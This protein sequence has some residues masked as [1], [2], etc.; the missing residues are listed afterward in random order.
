MSRGPGRARSCELC[1]NW[2]VLH[3]RRICSA[4]ERWKRDHPVRAVCP[5]CRHEDH[6]G[7]DG[8]CR[9]CLRAVRAE[10]DI[11][12]ALALP[13]ARPRDRQ[14]IIGTQRHYASRA[15]RI[16]RG[17]GRGHWVHTNWKRRLR[18]LQE[19]EH[20]RPA[21][22]P[23]QLWGQQAL[24]TLPRA[25]GLAT[26]SAVTTRSLPARAVVDPVVED[27]RAERA[28]THDW[29]LSVG[30]MTGLALAVSEA[31]GRL[32]APEELMRDLPAL[33]E[34]VC[35]VLHRAGLLAPAGSAPCD[36]GRKADSGIRP[37]SVAPVPPRSCEDCGAWM[38]GG[39]PTG[40]LC[41]FCRYWRARRPVGRCVRCHRDGLPLGRGHCR[42][43]RPFRGDHQGPGRAA[44][45][46]LMIDMLPGPPLPGLPRATPHPPPLPA[47]TPGTLACRGQ[48][49]LFALRRSWAPV[50]EHLKGR[51]VSDLPLTAPA[52]ALVAALARACCD[53][54][55]TGTA[56]NIRTLTVLAWWLGTDNPIHERDVHDLAHL[57]GHLMAKP[58]CQF[59]RGRGLLVDD[60]LLHRDRDQVWAE[61]VLRA[62]PPAVAD[63]LAAWAA[64]LR[65]RGRRAG[66]TRD[67]ALVRYYLAVLRSTLTAWTAAGVTSLRQITPEQVDDVLEDL[68]GTRRRQRAT[69]LRSLFRA[70]KYQRLIFQ[71]PARHLYVGDTLNIPRPL[72]SDLLAG[73]L[74]RARTPLARL[75]VVLA[76]VHAVP[77]GEIRAARTAG[78]DLAH[79]TLT[80]RRGLRRHTLHLED[81]TLRLASDW[82]TYRHER[83]P[84]STN[85]HLLVSQKTAGD[86]DHP[87]IARATLQLVL[88]EGATLDRLRRDRILDEA[89]TT[90]DPL[91]L[92]RLFGIVEETAMRYVSTAYPERTAK[93]PR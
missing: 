29:G 77:A 49:S 74:D 73:L 15:V 8:F 79:A 34:A 37:D 10:D 46:Q 86:P 70:L 47:L 68:N 5:R 31:E 12:W 78:L 30:R 51:P 81:L 9:P 25:L 52:A 45:T 13:G 92:M 40:P 33:G 27:V 17:D 76:A 69:A 61:R 7:P 18:S 42:A 57:S 39:E 60:P 4:C 20:E 36:S 41:R 24:F 84:T 89:V 53:K 19:Q 72:P 87:P 59:L 44:D 14:L 64:L 43:C 11:D 28:L 32:L 67:W 80:L 83:W 62:L 65:S 85:P 82:L 75:A 54:S 38:A 16:T 88:P 48:V 58:V 91:H 2:T 22:L 35:L 1:L 71:D 26:A 66:E 50:L 93:L 23:S 3:Q 63:E 90:G 55:E 21:V 56:K 6:L